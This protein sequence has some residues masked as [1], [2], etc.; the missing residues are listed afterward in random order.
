MS[1]LRPAA[2]IDDRSK[3]TVYRPASDPHDRVS[4]AVQQVKMMQDAKKSRNPSVA[5]FPVTTAIEARERVGVAQLKAASAAK[6]LGTLSSLMQT[7]RSFGFATHRQAR[8]AIASGESRPRKRVFT[9]VRSVPTPLSLPRGNLATRFDRL[10]GDIPVH[11]CTLMAGSVCVA[12]GLSQLTLLSARDP[13]ASPL[14]LAI[15]MMGLAAATCAGMLS[16]R[17][18]LQKAPSTVTSTRVRDA[19]SD[20]EKALLRRLR[21]K[22][23]RITYRR[24]GWRT[25]GSLPAPAT[26]TDLNA[27]I[28]DRFARVDHD[29]R[30]I[31][32]N[33]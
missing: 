19:M 22:P 13:G 21:Q 18:S 29:T 31:V 3:R 30:C 27:L 33:K 5:R 12:C 17:R 11:E 15:A 26:M 23:I 9:G 1:V 28:R 32:V 7:L 10:T 14:T 6:R 20:G 2:L 4:G 24:D 8:N 25:E 16:W